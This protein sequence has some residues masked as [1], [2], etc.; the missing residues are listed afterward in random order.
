MEVWKEVKGFEGLYEVSNK[1][2]VRSLDRMVRNREHDYHAKGRI[3]KLYTKSSGYVFVRLADNG[4]IKTLYVHRLIAEAF[5]LN[6]S[7]QSQINHKDENKANNLLENLEWCSASYNINYGDRSM[8][9]TRTKNKNGSI[10]AERQVV[11]YDLNDRF[12]EEYASVKIAAENNGVFRSNIYKC[13]CGKYKQTGG[14]KWKFKD[15][16]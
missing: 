11:K 13:C 1:G 7:N 5:L 8:K 16:L 10:G 4:K 12:L 6:P 3:L 14:F 9:V 15:Q 2:R